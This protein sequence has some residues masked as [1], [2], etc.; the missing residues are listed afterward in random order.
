MRE[1]GA[2][3]EKDVAGEYNIFRWRNSPWNTNFHDYIKDYK[4]T[5]PGA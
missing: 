1:E 5:Y 2:S 4:A 3:L